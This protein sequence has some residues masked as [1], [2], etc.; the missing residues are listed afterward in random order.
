[1]TPIHLPDF[2]DHS[3]PSS[4]APSPQRPGE[5]KTQAM[6]R[7]ATELNVAKMA[8]THAER[9]LLELQDTV[10]MKEKVNLEIWILKPFSERLESLTWIFGSQ[11]SEVASQQCEAAWDAMAELRQQLAAQE[12]VSEMRVLKAHCLERG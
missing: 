11:L 4:S 10:Q 6:A 1:M 5:S 3:I 9:K 2:R 12:M 8:K 7:L